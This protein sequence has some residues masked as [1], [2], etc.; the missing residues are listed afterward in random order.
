MT[1]GRPL[2][3]SELVTGHGHRDFEGVASARPPIVDSDVVSLANHEWRRHVH[4]CVQ[5]SAESGITPGTLPQSPGAII[6]HF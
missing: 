5:V 2:H 4:S 3:S 1:M 6:R